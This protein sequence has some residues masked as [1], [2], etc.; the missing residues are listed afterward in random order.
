MRGSRRGGRARALGDAPGGAAPFAGVAVAPAELLDAQQQ[1]VAVAVDPQ[2]ARVLDVPRGVALAPELLAAAAPVPDAPGLDRE[3][4]RLLVHVGDAQH[5]VRVGVLDDDGHEPRRVEAD[6]PE[7]LRVDDERRAVG[8]G[9]PLTR[10]FYAVASGAHR[11]SPVPPLMRSDATAWMS[12]SRRI[13]YSSP[14]T[15]TSKR[16]SGLKSTLSPGLMERTWG[17]TATVSA[18]TSRRDTWAVAG[19]RI[20]ARERRSPSLWVTWTSTRSNRTSM[21]CL[22]CEA[23]TGSLFAIRARYQSQ[24]SPQA[25]GQ[26][27]GTPRATL[28]L[29]GGPQR[30]WRPEVLGRTVTPCSV[31]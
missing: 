14:W 31:R 27:L 30:T 9:G 4:E 16:S 25:H 8:H 11:Y 20:P 5:A 2:L 28:A 3:A 10:R 26:G 29:A 19:M 21:G 7:D 23:G 17:P 22:S 13:T 6:Q 18:H 12:R 24:A 1:R 15:S